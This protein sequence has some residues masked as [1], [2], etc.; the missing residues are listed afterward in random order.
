METICCI[1]D[2]I[3]KG[4]YK[5][6]L[7][8]VRMELRGFKSFADKVVIPFQEGVTAIIGPNGCGKSNVAD[9]IRWTLGEKSA[10]QLRGKQMTDVIFAGTEKRKSLSYC[11][12]TLVFNNDN[13][14]IF[15]GLG[16]D[17]V[18]ITRKLDRSGKS[19]YYINNNRC[20]RQDIMK[21]FSD[22]GAGKDGYSIIGQG[23]IDEI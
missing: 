15:P 19:E 21:L 3:I 13:N 12:V 6:L 20:L 17:E 14:H 1:I 16:L 8:F 5:I 7:N 18:A 11:E 22:T 9:A 10:K 23:K 2:N 4:R